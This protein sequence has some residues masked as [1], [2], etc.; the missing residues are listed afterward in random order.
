MTDHSQQTTAHL[1]EPQT[2]FSQVS[3]EKADNQKNYSDFKYDNAP[4]GHSQNRVFQNNVF[5]ISY[6][7]ELP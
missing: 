7:K 5:D 3:G 6:S 1:I 4:Q 2:V